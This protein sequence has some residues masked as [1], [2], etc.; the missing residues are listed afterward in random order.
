MLDFK[1]M[2][3]FFCNINLFAVGEEKKSVFFFWIQRTYMVSF[4]GPI[5][6]PP[7]IPRVSSRFCCWKLKNLIL[8]SNVSSWF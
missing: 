7:K 2:I 8:I 5:I 1:N 4:A 6:F 3:L